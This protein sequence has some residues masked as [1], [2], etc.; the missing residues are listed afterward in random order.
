MLTERRHRL[1]PLHAMALAALLAIAFAVRVGMLWRGVYLVHPDETFQYFEYG[2]Y[3]VYRTGVMPWEFFSGIRSYFLPGLIAGIIEV[4]K[5]SGSSSPAI[6]IYAVKTCAILLSLS[7]VYIG[8]QAGRRVFGSSGALITGAICALWFELIYFAPAILTE[9]LASHLALWGIYL[10]HSDQRSTRSKMIAG[11]VLGLAAC[12]RFHYAPAIAI[13]L[14]WELQRDRRG[15]LIAVASAGAVALLIGGVLDTLTLGLPFQSIWYYFWLNVVENVSGEFGTDAWYGYVRM[16]L[17]SWTPL[18]WPFAILAAIGLSRWPALALASITVIVS[19][20]IFGH[21]EYRFIYFSLMTAPI[22]IGLG[23]ASVFSSYRRFLDRTT[24]PLAQGSLV[25]ALALGSY[26]A[27]THG[28]LAQRFG[29]NRNG[30]HAFLA[31]H[32]LQD[33]CSL[34]VKGVHWAL[35][36]GG[37]SYFNRPV[38]LYYATGLPGRLQVVL[39]GRKLEHYGNGDAV[40]ANDAAFMRHADRFNYLILPAGQSVTNYREVTC[41]RDAGGGSQVCI[42]RRDGPCKI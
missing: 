6:Y 22:F 36:G 4:V 9:V 10:L 35:T 28:S 14:F 8:F 17:E 20:S 33:I 40:G 7:V 42:A 25:L 21:K 34:G 11:A 15:L 3:L 29:A 12:L 1:P 19:Q 39:D 2:H 32:E 16:V 38:P 23:A 5:A 41:F 31:A 18:L 26:M 30:F 27:A 37:Y 13:A 24:L